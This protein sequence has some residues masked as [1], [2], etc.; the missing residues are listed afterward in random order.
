MRGREAE[1]IECLDAVRAGD[2]RTLGQ[3]AELDSIRLHGVT[4]SADRERKLFAWEP[5]NIPLFRLCNRLRGE[6]VPVYFSTDTGPTTV[7]L[8]HRQHAETVVHAIEALGGYE[9]VCGSVAGP[10]RLLPLAEARDC[11]AGRGEVC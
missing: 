9:V 7:F 11:L 1:V 10:S 4:M 8:T 5:E 2:W 3:L 6:G